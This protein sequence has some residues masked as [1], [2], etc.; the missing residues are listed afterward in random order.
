MLT[1]HQ[2]SEIPERKTPKRKFASRPVAAPRRRREKVRMEST[3]L[4]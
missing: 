4:L 1:E 3:D 2:E